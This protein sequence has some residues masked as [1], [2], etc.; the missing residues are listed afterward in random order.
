MTTR[1]VARYFA[2]RAPRFLRSVDMRRS[3]PLLPAWL[4]PPLRLRSLRAPARQQVPHLP[5]GEPGHHHL[6]RV[7]THTCEGVCG[8]SVCR[9]KKVFK[10]RIT[11]YRCRWA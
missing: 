7:R 8:V 4:R 2:R 1:A 11:R 5:Q 10:T 3:L 9:V 6:R